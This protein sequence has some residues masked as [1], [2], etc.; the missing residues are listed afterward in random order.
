[1]TALG[2]IVSECWISIPEHFPHAEVITHVVMPN[3]MHGI[4][5]LHAG[6]RGGR[7]QSE[8]FQKPVAGSLPTLVRSFKAAVTRRAKRAGLAS[9]PIWQRNY[10]ERVIRNEKEYWAAAR[11]ILENPARWNLDRENPL[12]H[13]RAP[14]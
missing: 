1:M 4:V 12:R 8:R 14:D 13:S 3:H 5:V 9:H 6:A 11:Y 2:R 10:F 7:E